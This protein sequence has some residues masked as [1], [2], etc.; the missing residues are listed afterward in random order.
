LTTEKKEAELCARFTDIYYVP[1]TVVGERS[2]QTG[3]IKLRFEAVPLEGKRFRKGAKTM[4]YDFVE[5]LIKKE[6]LLEI[7][8]HLKKEKEQDL[9]IACN[10]EEVQ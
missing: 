9:C 2:L 5:I 8:E 6:V 7:L 4:P 10:P 1:V 3:K